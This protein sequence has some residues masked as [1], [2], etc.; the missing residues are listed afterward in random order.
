MLIP[1]LCLKSL[2]SDFFLMVS[3][4]ITKELNE[5]HLCLKSLMSDLFLMVSLTMTKEL[6]EDQAYPDHNKRAK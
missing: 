4:T 3:L 1:S 5:D 6:N 2:M